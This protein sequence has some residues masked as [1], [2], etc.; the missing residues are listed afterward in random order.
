MSLDT[1]SLW[2]VQKSAPH[3]A[4]TTLTYCLPFRLVMTNSIKCQ[5][6]ERGY[7]QDVRFRWGRRNTV[8]VRIKLCSTQV[9]SSSSPLL[10]HLPTP[11]CCQ[12]GLLLV[13]LTYSFTCSFDFSASV[14]STSLHLLIAFSGVRLSGSNVLLILPWSICY[15][16]VARCHL[17]N[18]RNLAANRLIQTLQDSSN[19]LYTFK[20][21]GLDVEAG[22]VMPV[23]RI[24]QPERG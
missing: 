5:C 3:I 12:L 24:I 10:L 1:N 13:K 8:F 7:T 15:W 21:P 20:M 9:I 11:F 16:H 17:S 4:L 19:L 2:S 6:L 22:D 18:H 14:S 23:V